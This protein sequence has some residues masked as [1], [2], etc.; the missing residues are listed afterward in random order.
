VCAG[1]A[2]THGMPDGIPCE[3]TALSS[4]PISLCLPCPLT[5]LELIEL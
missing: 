3:L 1:A 5:A 4:A 2:A